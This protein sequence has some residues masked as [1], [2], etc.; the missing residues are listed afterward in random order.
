MTLIE[1][2]RAAQ[3]AD[4]AFERAL[5]KAGYKSRWDWHKASD[6]RAE[7]LAAY[8]AK[9]HADKVMHNAFE[10]NRLRVDK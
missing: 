8:H 3:I 4:T 5:Q 10:A 1:S 9:V 6:P 2:I 7:L